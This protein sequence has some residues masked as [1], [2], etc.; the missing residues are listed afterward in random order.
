[1]IGKWKELLKAPLG[2]GAIRKGLEKTV[3]KE[4]SFFN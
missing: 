2:D 4:G 3:V 1:M